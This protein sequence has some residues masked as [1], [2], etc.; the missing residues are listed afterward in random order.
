M[1]KEYSQLDLDNFDKIKISQK[2]NSTPTKDKPYR[3]DTKLLD[4]STKQVKGQYYK[5]KDKNQFS[6]IENTLATSQISEETKY[7]FSQNTIDDSSGYRS[8]YPHNIRYG[9]SK[10]KRP[11]IKV[12]INEDGTSPKLTWNND[13]DSSS[14]IFK[15]MYDE[16]KYLP[17][18][19]KYLLVEFG[20]IMSLEL[21]FKA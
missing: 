11:S 9:K 4:K 7:F 19:D 17:G 6:L 16:P 14:E 12:H 21:N 15:G 2:K 10:I 3:H 20:N 8:M 18:G 5:Q 1:V 13:S